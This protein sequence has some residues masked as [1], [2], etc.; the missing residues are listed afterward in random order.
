M[1]TYEEF[2]RFQSENTAQHAELNGKIE[3]IETEVHSVREAV[4]GVETRVAVLAERTNGVQRSLEFTNRLLVAILGTMFATFA[5]M[6]Y[7][8]LTR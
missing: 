2:N 6:L 1:V 5:G 8:F 7:T 3:Q 4:H